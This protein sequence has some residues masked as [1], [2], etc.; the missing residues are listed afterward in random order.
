VFSID[1]PP[2]AALSESRALFELGLIFVLAAAAPL[3]AEKL[4]LPSILALLAFGFGAGEIGALNPNELLGESLISATVSIAVGI[5]LFDSGLDLKIRDLGGGVHRVYRRLVSIGVLITW[6]IATVASHYFFDLSLQVALVVGAVLVVSG[7]TVV[8]PLLEFIRPSKRVDSVLRWE[9]TLADPVGATLGVVV[10]QAVLAGHA[11]PGHEVFEFLLS[12]GVGTGMGVAGA[13][14]ALGWSAWFKPKQSQAVTGTLMIVV[15][16]VAGADLLRDDSGLI[17]GLLIGAIFANRHMR[18]ARPKGLA[19]QSAKLARAWRG[20]IANLSTFLIGTLFI[21]LSARVSP[22]QL[23]A[24][25]WI[26]VAFVAVLVFVARPLAVAVSTLGSELNLRE[27]AFVA[28]MAPRGIVA[29]AT[30]STFALGLTQAEFAGAGKLIPV[31]FIVIVA[32]ALIYGLTGP[33]VARALGISKTGPGGVLLIGATPVGR[34]IGRGLKDA[35]LDVAVWTG[36]EARATAAR[37]EGLEVYEGDPTEDATAD[38]PS[39]LDG[40]EQALVVG[41]DEAL[42][43]MVATDLSEYFGREK[44][45]Q[46]AVP[47]GETSDFYTRVSVLFDQRATHDA[48]A[49]RIESGARVRVVEESVGLP[50]FAHRPGVHLRVVVAGDHLELQAEEELICLSGSV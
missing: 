29:A 5:I 2:L 13:A 25:G 27:R 26:S 45:F 12:V 31:V 42:N 22:H 17:T 37:A 7:P 41:E 23:E 24:V 18:V 50:M 6:A 20:R 4:R 43:A 15:A 14:M 35:G 33:P 48:L 49:T 28:W 46:L 30:S 44:V 3:I 1:P 21:V 40:M 34:A 8:G 19:I 16:A 39:D 38:G 11:K 9:G 10:F 47:D 32:T 36:N